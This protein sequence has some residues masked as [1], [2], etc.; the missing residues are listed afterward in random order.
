MRAPIIER[1]KRLLHNRRTIPFSL[2]LSPNA[3]LFS[4]STFL[5]LLPLLD[6]VGRLVVI[7][8]SV[9]EPLLSS[10]TVNN[11]IRVSAVPP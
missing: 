7:V 1:R 9:D 4:P 5:P 11:T 6:V 8:N 2:Y 3:F 10:P